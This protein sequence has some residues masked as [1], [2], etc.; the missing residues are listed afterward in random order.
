MANGVEHVA[1]AT[2]LASDLAGKCTEAML[3]WGRA[4]NRS[5][6]MPDDPALKRLAQLQG[7]RALELAMGIARILK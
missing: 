6:D 5:E 7:L 1:R 3:E 2:A 4:A